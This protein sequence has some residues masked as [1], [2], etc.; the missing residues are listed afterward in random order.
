MS[1]VKISL[2]GRWEF[3][4]DPGQAYAPDRLPEMRPIEV[5]ASWETQFPPS[6]A[7]KF[8][9]G[10]Y[11]KRFEAPA[12]WSGRAVFL[13][14]GAVNYYCQVWVN[15]QPVGEHEGGYTP[16]YF[17]ID[18]ALRPGA[19]NVLVV[20]VV[21]PA[22]AIP[23]F[24]AFSYQDIATSLQD[25]MTPDSFHFLS[26]RARASASI[27]RPAAARLSASA[28]TNVNPRNGSSDLGIRRSSFE[29]RI[30]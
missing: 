29:N 5:P 20:S 26:S 28:A 30:R 8:G 19:E 24:K 22:H 25:W 23:S 13:H 3:T 27:S 14:F 10:W 4:P 6:E 7:G 15:G 21:H 11:R 18:P 2:D 16:F 1:R 17:R 9:R 12:D